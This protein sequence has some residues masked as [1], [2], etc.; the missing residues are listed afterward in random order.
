[1][2]DKINKYLIIG[3]GVGAAVIIGI[4]FGLY[5][6]DATQP[7]ET[8]VEDLPQIISNYESDDLLKTNSE[9]RINEQCEI[10]YA[11]TASVYPNDEP[12]QPL[13]LLELVDKYPENFAKWSNEFQN[14]NTTQAF[15]EAGLSPEFLSSFTDVVMI[16]YSINPELKPTALLAFL[17]DPSTGERLM[18][19][20]EDYECEAYYNERQ[21]ILEP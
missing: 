10:L 6:F 1:M 17:P 4:V 3:G 2:A 12:L 20:Y 13:S 19:L 18:E 7:A 15:L 16:E 21:N 9:Y 8:P 14:E 5:S 11:M